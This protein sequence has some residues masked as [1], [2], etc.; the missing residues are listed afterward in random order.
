[1]RKRGIMAK[2]TI[3]GG[4]SWGIALAV[5]L[6]KNGHE[7]CIWSVL[8]QEIQMLRETHEHKML[9][10]VKLPEDMM[11]TTDLKSA[12]EG[13]DILVLAV[14]SPFV[15]GTAHNMKDY[16]TEGQVIG[17]VAGPTKY[18]VTEG[19]NLYFAMKRN[20]KAVNPEGMFR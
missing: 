13:K 1:M 15:R 17:T 8:E 2:I 3:L 18:Y 4:G 20:G 10:G 11:F 5:L 7:T 14:P 19:N 16:V 9:P 12:V 6:H